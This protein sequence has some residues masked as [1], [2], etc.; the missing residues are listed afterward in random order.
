MVSQWRSI[1]CFKVTEITHKFGLL[2][3]CFNM[4]FQRILGSRFITAIQAFYIFLVLRL[5]VYID[6]TLIFS[7]ISANITLVQDR[8]IGM[9]LNMFFQ[10][11]RVCKCFPTNRTGRA[12]LRLFNKRSS[13]YL[14]CHLWQS[15]HNWLMFTIVYN[16]AILHMKWPP[17]ETSFF[18]HFFNTKT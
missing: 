17:G 3:L 5:F 18:G 16:K 15:Q 2:M 14:V 13:D 9:H 12:W 8:C 11:W 4:L 6:L 1:A 10:E 7:F